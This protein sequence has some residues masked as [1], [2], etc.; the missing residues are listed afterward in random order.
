MKRKENI[1]LFQL[2][3]NFDKENGRKKNLLGFFFLWKN[4]NIINFFEKK[5]IL[6][7]QIE[8]KIPNR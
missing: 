4:I 8:S 1:F 7:I 5:I 2:I 6:L 3:S